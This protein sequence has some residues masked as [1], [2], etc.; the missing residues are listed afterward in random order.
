MIASPN[1][2]VIL[3][4]DP[5][6]ARRLRV[7]GH[8]RV[9]LAPGLEVALPDGATLLINLGKCQCDTEALSAGQDCWARETAGTMPTS[10]TMSVLSLV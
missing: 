2:I 4:D 8:L 6:A 10:T 7:V 9:D 5:E 1:E 3:A